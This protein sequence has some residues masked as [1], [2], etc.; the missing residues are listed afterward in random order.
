MKKRAT[1]V[2]L[3][4]LMIVSLMTALGAGSLA[5]GSR[6]EEVTALSAGGEYILA[7]VKDDDSVYAIKKGSDIT[8]AT[9]AVTAAGGSEPAY[10]ETDDAAVVWSYTSEGYFTNGSDY[11]Y[12]T[13]N[14]RIM[15]YSSSRK[16]IFSEGH[17]YFSS[18]S[19]GTYFLT[20]DDGSFS[21]S[22]TEGDAA[23]FRVFGKTAGS[24][25]DP[26]PAGETETYRLTEALQDGGEYLIV[27]SDAAGSAYALTNPGG[28]SSG[29]TMG[30]T[31][32][33]ILEDG[34]VKTAATDIVWTATPG[35]GERFVLRNGSDYLEGKS[36]NV[37][38]WTAQQYADRGWT[39]ADNLLKFSGDTTSTTYTVYYSNGFTSSTSAQNA[40]YLYEKV[41]DSTEPAAVTG[42]TLNKTELTLE[43]G[44]S[45]T[46]TATVQP[47]NAENKAVNWSSSNEAAATVDAS[48]KITA[49]AEGA[50]VIT[51]T[52]ADGGK[53]A[54]CTVTVKKAAEKETFQLVSTLQDGGEYLIVSANSAGSAYALT[55]PGG[56]S[57]GADMGR[58]AVTVLEDETI[59]TAAGDVVWIATANGGG[60]N[61][62]NGTD[63]LEG[64]S[65]EVKIFSAVQY[66]DRYWTYSGT[67]LQHVGGNN[68]Y[69]VYYSNGFTATY[70]STTE[71]IYLYE[72]VSGS[73]EPA[74]VTG[75][76]LN[77]TE[78]T[79]EAGET[80]TLT[81]TVQPRNAE[82]K[83]VSWSSSNEAAATVDVSGKITAVAEGA[84]VITVTTADGGK[85]AT[86][87]VTVK[88]AT[89][90]ETYRL[91]S[92]MQ[93]G[94]EY[95]IV[96]SSSAGSAYALTNPGGSSSGADMGRTE[97]TILDDGTIR[98]AA[99]DIV[100]KASA[101][102][103]RFNLTNGADYLE[104]KSGNVKVFSSQQ[105][106]ARGWVYT[107]S[108]LQHMG[109]ENAYTVYY[110]SGFTSTYNTTTETVYLFEKTGGTA[111]PEPSPETTVK[112]FMKLKE[113]SLWL[114]KAEAAEGKRVTYKGET[115]LWSS[116]YGAYVC[117]VSA[118]TEPMVSAGDLDVTSGTSAAIGYPSN[119]NDANG[120]AK[121]DMSDVQYI[122]N[123]YSGK[124]AS[125][126]SA[127]GVEKVLKADVNGDG[128]VTSA[129]G[130]TV[131]QAVR[132]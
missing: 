112:E 87:A 90:K 49:V 68:S 85:T 99:A 55:N 24:S 3:V 88:K 95:L 22:S 70:N 36:G 53:T 98:T 20:C 84:A 81:A 4:L 31:A 37:K 58:T 10:V 25:S 40:V 44:E 27:S 38:I 86:C 92:V 39:Y 113:S 132:G 66:A 108:Q 57:N 17:L 125:L 13:S 97:V 60:F 19:S 116:R 14:G 48:G 93:D 100:W 111:E 83:T 46:L 30:R 119:I 43:A 114:I 63:T 67:Q 74:A 91:V 62:T 109:G 26:T 126:S 64:K 29:A 94:G 69:T 105:Y 8:S 110:S 121:V 12:P 101:N 131:L 45:E 115:M 106:A 52:T 54:T 96:S 102:D 129:D 9:L 35:Q 79:L 78:L 5:A 89:E 123:L 73:T 34:T 28:T 118:E 104:G 56:T 21:T 65:G 61:L 128:A 72:K 75:V 120:S 32:V 80:E 117:V 71:K 23:T 107:N 18:S 77:K 42:V 47:R 122:Y 7:A 15:S 2:L 127:G 50:A 41:S 11:L 124:Y 51:A 33:T 6:Y 16:I 82:N 76:V 1:A 130:E 103:E 59:R